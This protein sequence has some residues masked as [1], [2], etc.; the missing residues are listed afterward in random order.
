MP[1]IDVRCLTCGHIAEQYRAVALFPATHPCEQCGEATEQIH[2]PKATRWTPDPVIVFKA[3]DGSFRFPG[4]NDGLSVKHYE[5]QGFQR[6]EIRGAVEM[7]TFERTMNR[8]E[9][10][11]M[12]RQVERKQQARERR[13]ADTRGQLRQQMQSMSAMG[14][15]LALAAMRRNDA[16]AT[17]RAG[18]ANFHNQAYSFDRSNREESRG[19]DGR[20]R[21]D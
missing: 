20:R 6:V 14:R 10:A 11:K 8:I 1:I 21:R 19:S 15:D 5:Q 4:D 3:P 9:Y 2:Q 18:D 12:Q 17:A 16:K 13:E 7:R